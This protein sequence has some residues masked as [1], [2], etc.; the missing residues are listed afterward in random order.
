MSN[1]WKWAALSAALLAACAPPQKVR[2]LVKMRPGQ[3]SVFL[4]GVLKPFEKKN[5]CVIE[6]A[7]YE[8][9][10]TLQD[11]LARPDDSIDLVHTPLDMTRALVGRGLVAPLDEG[12]PP[13]EIPELRKEYFLMDL[14]AVRNQYYFLPHFL[15]TPVLVYMKSQV[16]EAVQYWELHKPEINKALARYN[17]KGLPRNYELEKDPSQWDFFDLFVAGYYWSVKEVRGERRGR[18]ALGSVLSPRTPR[19]LIDKCFQAGANSDAVLRMSDEGVADAFQWQSV[20]IREGVINPGLVK[21]KWGEE[22]IWQGLQ[23]G[24]IFLAEATQLDAFLIH[25]N[26]T[27]QM[28]GFLSDPEDMGLALMPKGCSLLLGPKGFPQ[29]EGRRAVAT[30]DWWWG[31]T[32]RAV[33]KPLAFKLAHYLSNT[34]NQIEECG[35]FGMVPARQDLLGELGLMFGGGW[36][37]EVFQAASQQIVEN[38]YT[39]FPMVE[40][41]PEVA[42]NYEAAFRELCLPGATQRTR[43]EDIRKALDERFVPRQRQILGDKYPS[44][45]RSLSRAPDPARTRPD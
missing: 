38:R 17:G 10:A 32:R 35:T 13:Q 8:D 3:K 6:V 21:N 4:A 2:M 31:V 40:E 12:A 7:T 33:D 5:N 45:P 34:R 23:S 14:A 11:L 37:S 43:F 20:L 27:P 28:P 22:K 42:A 19:G 26:G 39:V 44:G 24:E 16:A 30:R 29:R 41:F 36:T 9:P 18:M 1:P 15:E 25:G